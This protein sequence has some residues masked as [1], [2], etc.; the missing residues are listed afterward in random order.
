MSAIPVILSSLVLGRSLDGIVQ[1]RTLALVR[2]QAE[3]VT[4]L[5]IEPHLSVKDLEGPLSSKARRQFSE[6]LA[7]APVDDY[8]AGFKVWGPKRQLVF[9]ENGNLKKSMLPASD[10]LDQALQGET[11]SSRING[12]GTKEDGGSKNPQL[13]EVYVPLTFA[14][15][16]EPSGAVQLYLPYAPIAQIIQQ[17][18]HRLYLILLCGFTLFY[19]VLFRIVARASTKLKRQAEDNEYLALHDSLTGLPNRSLF[20]ERAGQAILVARREGWNLAV[21]I[22]DLDRFKEINDTLGHHHGDLVLQEMGNRLRPLLRE[23]DT[24]ARLGGDEFAVLLPHV[25][26]T[27]TTLQVAD[28]IQKAL[29]RPFYIQGLALDI[30]ASVG[31]AIFP[32]HGKDIHG[33][34]RR[35]DVAMYVAKQ[36]GSGRQVYIEEIDNHNPDRLGLGGDLR[37]AIE[38]NELVL[39]YQPLIGLKDDKL[40]SVEALVRWVHPA[41]GV[42]PPAEFIAVAERGG[43]IGPLT[44]AVLNTAL[45]QCHEWDQQGLTINVAVNLSVRNLLD[46]RFPAEVDRLLQKWEIDP[47]RLELEITESSIMADPARAMEILTTLHKLGVRLAVDDFGTGYSSL[48]SLKRLPINAVK[49]D[50]TF[51]QSMQSDENDL[52]IVQSIIDLAHNMGLEVVAEGVENAQVVEM[53]KLLG[54]DFIQGWHRGR[55]VPAKEIPWLLGVMQTTAD[56]VPPPPPPP[57]PPSGGPAV[58]ARF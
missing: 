58:G 5:R 36:T 9:Q 45:R 37:N 27:N 15:E 54:C 44:M 7:A 46:P 35:A 13:I 50:K 23:T 30:D 12:E 40:R 25:H 11:V 4:T 51:V 29:E 24:V 55:P 41:R 20:H 33:L 18:N 2:E 56:A 43:L 17:D 49:I 28:K 42:L 48:S 8:I 53:L 22:M 6:S 34:L 19:A 26:S 52:L 3:L 38:R 39:H 31:I 57:P 21:M 10:L 47:I 14:G 16:A 1:K 32:T